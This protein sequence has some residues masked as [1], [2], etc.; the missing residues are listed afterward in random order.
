MQHMVN[1]IAHGTLSP[2]PCAS[3]RQVGAT[4]GAVRGEKS[5]RRLHYFPMALPRLPAK[6]AAQ[7]LDVGGSCSAACST[8]VV[9]RPGDG[10]ASTPAR[11]AAIASTEILAIARRST[12]DD[13]VT[14]VRYL[15]NRHGAAKRH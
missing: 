3:L 9:P 13:P 15:V 7:L 12:V 5:T 14:G 8:T 2:M 11:P 4:Q 1:R 6:A 10:G